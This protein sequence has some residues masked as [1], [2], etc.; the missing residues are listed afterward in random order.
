VREA[1]LM[2]GYYQEPELTAATVQEGWLRT[3]DLGYQANGSL[4]I[5]WP[6]SLAGDTLKR[7]PLRSRFAERAGVTPCA[8]SQS[9]SFLSCSPSRPY[10]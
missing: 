10:A 3:R 6:D 1:T 8:S 9:Q 4:F 7:C 2:D 5:L